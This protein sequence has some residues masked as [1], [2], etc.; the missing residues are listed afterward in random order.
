M[1]L[2][3]FWTQTAEIQLAEI[4]QYY[5][6]VASETIAKRIVVEIVDATIQLENFPET[7]QI[8]ELLLK[9]KNEYR[10]IVQGNYKIIYWI[11]DR[12]VKIATVFDCRQNPKKLKK[13]VK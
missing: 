9:R 2:S 5:K 8:E 7:G 4:F 1:A 12:F 3:V 10:Y 11:D 13:V 6:D